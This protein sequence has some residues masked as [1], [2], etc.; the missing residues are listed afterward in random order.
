MQDRLENLEVK[1]AYLERH[2]AE[3]DAV[4]REL[5]DHLADVRKD[6]AAVRTAQAAPPAEESEAEG[7]IYEVPPHY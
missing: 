3:L 1:M 4:V 6:L 7:P 5:A 2:L